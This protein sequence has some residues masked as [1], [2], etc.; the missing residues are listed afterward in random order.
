MALQPY[1]L[2]M[3]YQGRARWIVDPTAFLQLALGSDTSPH[4]PCAPGMGGGR[5]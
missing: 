4:N 2:E 1:L 5:D 3:G